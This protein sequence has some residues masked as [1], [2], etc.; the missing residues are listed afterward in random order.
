MPWH[1]A[2]S[3]CAWKP[4]FTN[5]KLS[6]C[7]SESGFSVFHRSGLIEKIR[8]V[9]ALR[10]GSLDGIYAVGPQAGGLEGRSSSKIFFFRTLPERRLWQSTKRGILGRLASQT[11]P[12]RKPR[13]QTTA[14]INIG[15]VQMYCE[16]G[17]ITA[18]L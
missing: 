6:S 16:K 14:M 1:T 18:N 7:M 4:A 12:P 17:A 3:F 10:S 11:P 13:Q 5:A 8:S 9:C 15:L 2:W